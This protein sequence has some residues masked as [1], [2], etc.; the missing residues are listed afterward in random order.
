[1]KTKMPQNLEALKDM[2]LEVLL[3]TDQLD[4]WY[5]SALDYVQELVDDEMV[6]DNPGAVWTAVLDRLEMLIDE[7]REIAGKGLEQLRGLM[8]K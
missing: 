3:A 4:G 2:P 6:E 1:M 5:G 7:Q 8:C